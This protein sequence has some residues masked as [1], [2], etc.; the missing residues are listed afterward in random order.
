[1]APVEIPKRGPR[2]WPSSHLSWTGNPATRLASLSTSAAPLVDT[3]HQKSLGPIH[4]ALSNVSWPAPYLPSLHSDG[5]FIIAGRTSHCAMGAL[6][7]IVLCCCCSLSVGT[8]LTLPHSLLPTSYMD[9]M[10]T[11]AV[12]LLLRL[13]Y[14]MYTGRSARRV[15]DTVFLA[16]LC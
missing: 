5:V 9:A 11:P 8:H 14:S 6:G 2:K 10:I 16:L 4:A 12:V 7:L 13:L 3:S 15:E 1:M